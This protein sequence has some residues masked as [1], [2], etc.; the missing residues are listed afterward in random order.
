MVAVEV[1][2]AAEEAEEVEGRCKPLLSL[3]S[4]TFCL[5]SAESL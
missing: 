3:L 2:R 4:V 1:L 5:A